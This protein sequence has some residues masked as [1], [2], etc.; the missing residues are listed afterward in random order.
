LKNSKLYF[1]FDTPPYI[2]EKKFKFKY[3][4]RRLKK[5]FI[6]VLENAETN[7]LKNLGSMF[8]FEIKIDIRMCS[9]KFWF[10]PSIS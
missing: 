4:P 10:Y 8:S 2:Q 7:Q 5:D 9:K 6:F 1:H 3:V